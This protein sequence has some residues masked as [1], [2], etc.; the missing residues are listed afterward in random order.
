MAH[1]AE[2]FPGG[3]LQKCGYIIFLNKKRFTQNISSAFPDK[4]TEKLYK[5]NPINWKYFRIL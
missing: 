5:Y 1:V 2:K 3:I 4:N